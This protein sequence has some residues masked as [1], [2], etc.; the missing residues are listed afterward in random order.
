MVSPGHGSARQ[1][2]SR[3][4]SSFSQVAAGHGI[5]EQRPRVD[6]IDTCSVLRIHL[7]D[8][9]SK[10]GALNKVNKRSAFA[11]SK[12]F[13][14]PLV[15]QVNSRRSFLCW[16]CDFWLKKIA[17]LFCGDSMDLV[18]ALVQAAGVGVG[19][20]MQKSNKREEKCRASRRAPMTS[21]ESLRGP[22]RCTSIF[23][24]HVPFPPPSF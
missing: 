10:S 16:I 15:N 24:D 18:R 22:V 20:R 8:L 13:Q 12:G 17:C 4:C 14:I 5:G 19:W 7:L 11:G 6:S 1:Q 23:L 9:V 3:P 2:R 21:Q